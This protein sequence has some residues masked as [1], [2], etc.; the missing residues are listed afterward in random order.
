MRNGQRQ[1][2][3]YNWD[4]RSPN[5]NHEGGRGSFVPNI[6]ERVIFLLQ[7]EYSKRSCGLPALKAVQLTPLTPYFSVFC[8]IARNVNSDKGT[9][10]VAR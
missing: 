9:L 7:V 1:R 10:L 6:G 3:I 4:E 8:T 2:A 5:T